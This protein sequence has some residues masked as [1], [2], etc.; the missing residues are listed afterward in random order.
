MPSASQVMSSQRLANEELL[1]QPLA[2]KCYSSPLCANSFL[3]R[4]AKSGGQGC[5]KLNSSKRKFVTMFSNCA[6]VFILLILGVGKAWDGFHTLH[7]EEGWVW[8]LKKRT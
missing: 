5:I 6:A 2:L 4:S 8:E 1:W 3:L 7:D